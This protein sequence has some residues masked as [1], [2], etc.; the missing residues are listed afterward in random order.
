M[1][2]DKVANISSINK[3]KGALEKRGFEVFVLKNKTEAL[4]K[5]KDIIPKGASVNNGSSTTLTEI[6]FIDYLK[7]NKHSWNNLHALVVEEKDSNKQ[8]EL[9]KHAMFADY[10]L[11]SVH[12]L[13]ETG[14]IVIASASGSQLVPIV[15]GSRNLIFVVGAQKITKSYEDAMNRLRNHVVALED[16]RMKNVGMGGT[17]LSK[18]LTIEN[19]PV[20]MGR[21]VKIIIVQEKLGF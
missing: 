11:G 12:S 10:Y 1:K 20:F 9:R 3:A 14:E 16:I 19:E 18:I 17:T 15:Y 4:L 21:S 2:Y 7:S 5:I 13:A 6:G 8:A